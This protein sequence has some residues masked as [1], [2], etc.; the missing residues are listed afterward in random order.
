M[1][2][3]KMV[4]VGF[5][6]LCFMLGF[7]VNVNAGPITTLYDVEIKTEGGNN[8]YAKMSFPSDTGVSGTY[9]THYKL[10]TG[11]NILEAF[12]I[13]EADAISPSDYEVYA[14]SEAI[15]EL[16]LDS[17]RMYQ[18]A[19][20]ANTYADADDPN[21]AAAQMAIWNLA[22]DNDYSLTEN[23]GSVWSKT[24][25]LVTGANS[26]LDNVYGQSYDYD[27]GWAIAHNPINGDFDNFG[28]QDYLIKNPVP[29]PATILLLGIG[30]VGLGTYTRKFR[31]A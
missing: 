28:S 23:E 20:I 8:S 18:A 10:E 2:S 26:I 11:G 29:E 1:V 15:D 14:L 5:V 22:M 24:A 4:L 13:E 6:V 3:K 16:E 19:Y 27:F 12:C 31:K 9:Y 25:S 21:H 17:V 7:Q 30:L